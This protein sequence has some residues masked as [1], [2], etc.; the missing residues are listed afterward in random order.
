MR[1]HTRSLALP[2]AAVLLALP[3]LPARAQSVGS[4]TTTTE[5]EPQ[6]PGQP[7]REGQPAAPAAAKP[8][9]LWKGQNYFVIE[10]SLQLRTVGM[11]Q[12]TFSGAGGG[13]WPAYDIKATN[14]ALRMEGNG[15]AMEIGRAGMSF[16]SGG[17]TSNEKGL[18]MLG[19]ATNFGAMVSYQFPGTVIHVGLLW[20]ELLVRESTDFSETF[21][22]TVALA[23]PAV[24]FSAGPAVLD[25][26][27]AEV[28]LDLEMEKFP[29]LAG[30]TSS[31]ESRAGFS[32]VPAFEVRLGV[33]F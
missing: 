4:T 22:L 7:A 11:P 25:V 2:V 26:R 27:F 15:L 3:G 13:T 12:S 10:A 1:L 30:T 16:K 23:V 28:A 29:A 24:R 20:P 6:Q 31:L 19:V 8:R 21:L 14:L 32:F 18:F 17:A 9:D 5:P 33:W